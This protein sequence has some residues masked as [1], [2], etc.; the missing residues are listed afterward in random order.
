M[1]SSMIR[2]GS[3]RL[4]LPYLVCGPNSGPCEH[5]LTSVLDLGFLQELNIREHVGEGVETLASSELGKVEWVERLSSNFFKACR[6]EGRRCRLGRLLHKGSRRGDKRRKKSC[7]KL[8]HG[9]C[10]Y[11]QRRG[12]TAHCH[13][14]PTKLGVSVSNVMNDAA[15]RKGA[16][17]PCTSTLTSSTNDVIQKLNLS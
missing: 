11:V 6:L 14:E 3:M 7:C 12:V 17:N 10:S 16:A 2:L 13:R 1:Q 8:G 4:R 15:R 9:C 5:G